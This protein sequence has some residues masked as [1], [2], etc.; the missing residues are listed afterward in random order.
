MYLEAKKNNIEN[1]K[2]NYVNT[3]SNSYQYM[4]IV[5]KFGYIPT[6]EFLSLLKVQL[7]RILNNI[8]RICMN[9]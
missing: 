8:D 1:I 9:E 6:K 2:N 4:K 3:A 7:R 5:P